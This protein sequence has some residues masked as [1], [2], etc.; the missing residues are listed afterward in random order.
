MQNNNAAWGAGAVCAAMLATAALP[1][2][3]A[4]DERD[5]AIIVEAIEADR[6]ITNDLADRIWDLA[7]LGYQ[8]HL[9]SELL[10][11]RLALAGFDVEAGIAGLPTAFRATYRRG[12]GGGVIG[13]LAEFDALPGI[14]QDR[15]PERAILP[16][17]DAGHACGHNL[18]GAGS[19][20]AAI[21]V[22]AWM[23]ETDTA[24][25]I[26]VYGTPAEEGGSGK[27]YM[28]RAGV[29]DD[30]DAVLHW[31][32]DD[33]NSASPANNLANRSARFTFTGV[34]AHA[35]GA[36]ERG[37]SALDGVEAMDF[38][39]NMM[40]EHMPS[41]A[42]I[43][44]VITSGG[45]APNVVPD[46]AEVYYYVR[47]P[48][49]RELEHLWDRVVR[50][51]EAAAMG[52]ETEVSVEVM[53]GNLALLPNETLQAQLHRNLLTVSDINY[54]ADEAAFVRALQSTM[55][56]APIGHNPSSVQDYRLRQT[57]GSTDVGD[58]SWVAPTGG[59][60]A[61]TWAPG[62]AAHSWQA[63]AASGSSVGHKGMEVAA[64]ALALTA[65]DLLMD[66]SL[67]ARVR[68]EFEDRRG[69]GFTYRPLLGDR[70]PPLDYREAD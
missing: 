60:R 21:A 66:E 57:Y 47:H 32:P 34:S 41:D 6:E 45:S 49:V 17:R 33:E 8:E 43:H 24:G 58:V 18:F 42:R 10:Q 35:A 12:Q 69:R 7:E 46:H 39:V 44:Y 51:A 65:T 15:T 9:S 40:R 2:R 14:S 62:T 26:R 53:H 63:V 29:F 38:M 11:N 20:E 16:A 25:E 68:G 36:P 28:A 31:H 13:V 23:D 56:G 52:T 1:I 67:R 19:V 55:D 54:T 5:Y 3:A 48:D 70:D 61:A 30:V 50:A 22:A 4:A 27:V 37:R 59:M 64:K